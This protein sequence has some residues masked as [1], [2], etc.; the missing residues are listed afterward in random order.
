M[1]TMATDD[2]HD[3]GDEGAIISH[4]ARTLPRP[5][6]VAAS[7][8][9]P[10]PCDCVEGV[11]ASATDFSTSYPLE[12][13]APPGPSAMVSPGGLPAEGASSELHGEWAGDSVATAAPLA[14]VSSVLG[15]LFFLLSRNRCWL[16][17]FCL[18]LLLSLSMAETTS[19]LENPTILPPMNAL[20]FA[21][22]LKEACD[23]EVLLKFCRCK[24]SAFP[25]K[26]PPVGP[27]LGKGTP[28][29]PTPPAG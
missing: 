29:S 25:R 10:T 5:H 27:G 17:R 7:P 22:V 28:P 19:L 3:G 18:R 21:P 14:V 15:I 9:S 6:A 12:V 16:S 13:L 26:L 20:R 11:S 24:A 8:W 4:T 2:N 23:M 1:M